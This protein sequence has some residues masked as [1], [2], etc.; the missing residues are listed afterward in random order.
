MD[1]M[2]RI[3]GP[4]GALVCGCLLIACGGNSHRLGGDPDAGDSG[5]GTAGTTSSPGGQSCEQTIDT[6][7]LGCDATVMLRTHCAR[8]GCHNSATRSAQLDLTP[9][10]L[11]IA[12]V[13]DVPAPFSGISKLAFG[14]CL[15]AKCPPRGSVMLI[16]STSP[17]SSWML[18][19]MEAFDFDTPNG[20]P[21][22][23]CG[24]AM[25]YPPGGMGYTLERAACLTSFFLAIAQ[26]GVPCT[27]PSEPLPELP[28]CPDE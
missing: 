3:F 11:L 17:E 26:I 4:I 18:R 16:D 15:P 28:T 14:P 19:K 21:D 5:G 2:M 25:P 10:S 22:M 13:L 20:V 9:D 7:S 8:G 6:S 1:A 12:R 23:G 27:L 24:T